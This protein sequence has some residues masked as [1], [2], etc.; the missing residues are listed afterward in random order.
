MLRALHGGRHPMGQLGRCRACVWGD[1]ED[2]HEQHEQPPDSLHSA[3]ETCHGCEVLRG[4][5]E[6]SR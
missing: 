2:V 4:V 3:Y 5:H 6:A 1:E